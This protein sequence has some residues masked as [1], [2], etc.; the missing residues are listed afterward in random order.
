M[1]TLIKQEIFKL[2]KKRSTWIS[3]IV[4]VV[5][6]II[7]ALVVDKNPDLFS[8]ESLY[9]DGFAGLELVFFFMVAACSSIITMEFQYNTAKE[10][11]YRKYSRGQILISKWITLFLY[12]IYW[13]LLTY[14]VAFVLK[15][16]LFP[17]F[18]LAKNIGH[19]TT[20]IISQLQYVGSQFLGYWLI[21]TLVLLL[22][23]LFKS[24]AV[25]TSIGLI[26]YFLINIVSGLMVLLIQKWDWIKWN[27]LTMLMYPAQVQDNSTKALTHLTVNELF[28]GNI[29]YIVVFLVIG[30]AIY[31]KRT[32]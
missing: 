3:T 23:N 13:F 24:S 7:L 15:L 17:H 18:D 4:L 10:L 14:L 30:Y 31:R 22:A 9:M 16:I 8:L 28:T 2:T 19:G 11:F 1:G 5:L 25:A 32:V 27:P 12:S 20:F 21:L 6:Q 26:G 29:I